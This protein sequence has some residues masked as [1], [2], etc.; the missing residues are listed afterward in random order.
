VNEGDGELPAP[1]SSL[2]GR[3]D[4]LATVRDSLRRP[5]VRLLTLTGPGG[6]GKTRLAVALANDLG[7]DFADG[8][9]FV[10]LASLRD[11]NFVTTAIAQALGVQ[12][13]VDRSLAAT[14]AATL[15]DKRLLLVLDNFEQVGAA[16]PAVADLL[17]HCP[18][19]EVL[20]TSRAPL[21]VV[22]EWAF[23]VPALGLPAT[24]E[25]P[26]MEALTRYGAVRLFAE[27]VQ[28]V[29]PDFE[30]TDANAAQVVEVCRRLD[31]L[32]LA[33]ELAA[34][35]MKVLPLPSLLQRL[36]HRLPLLTGGPRD[37]LPRLRTMHDAIAWSYDLLIDEEQALFRKLA[38]FAGGFRLE[39][40]EAI[41]YQLSAIS[42]TEDEAIA[43]PSRL[44]GSSTSTVLDLIA[45]LVDKS[46]L[47][48]SEMAEGE[49]RFAMLETVREFALSQLMAHGEFKP[50]RRAHA[51]W[52]LELAERA[53]PHLNSGERMPWLRR[54]DSEHDNMRAALS[55]GRTSHQT[56]GPSARLAAALRLFWFYRGH[57]S[58]GRS[59]FEAY[60]A[61]SR[62]DS[63]EMTVARARLHFGVGHLAWMQAEYG[64]AREHL[65]HSVDLWSQLDSPRDLNYAKGFLGAVAMNQ[66]DAVT[67]RPYVLECLE[68]FSTSPDR[69]GYGFSQVN[70]GNLAMAERDEAEAARL[71][72]E[73][74]TTL[75]EVG[76][77]WL[78]SLPIRYLARMAYRHGDLARAAALQ[79][80][81]L[82][83]LK[84]PEERWYLSRSFEDLAVIA[85][86]QR[87][88]RRAARLLGASEVLR[89]AIGAPIYPRLRAEFDKAVTATQ[90][91]LGQDSFAA[92]WAEGRRLPLAEAIVEALDEGAGQATTT[93]ARAPS[94]AKLTE[95]ELEVLRLL[96]EGHTD[97]ESAAMLFISPRTVETHV[98]NFINKLG[99]S[100]RLAAV[101]YAA[102]H[103]LI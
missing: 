9:R 89:E 69:W 40:A 16:A 74:I 29:K 10:P 80:Q 83:L 62:G 15:R 93:S 75:G 76:D 70:A 21:H 52:C 96:A 56:D 6:V 64:V 57:W 34:V 12:E 71:Y 2:L 32:P 61:Q 97:R 68:Y 31:G 25:M 55:W 95:R 19:L 46:L 91:A 78:L 63:C 13:S 58:E 1:R 41:S 79:R 66:D 82:S 33:I 73:A 14:L 48:Q 22:G 28:A 53:E 100:S 37:Q 86:A 39:A 5:D 43:S 59:W 4:A 90:A 65:M 72:Q 87:D 88:F 103:G 99:L 44:L 94:A 85:A 3:E 30:L 26:G 23:P 20:V 42:P 102:R 84:E 24:G 11:A 27:R 49:P 8:V 60:L 81:S 47:R 77:D 45:S 51:S 17:D 7:A 92:T 50:V 35:W 18:R 36:D 54:L 67:A 101:V 38:A 98:T